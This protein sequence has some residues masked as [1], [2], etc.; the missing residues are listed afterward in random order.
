MTPLWLD[1][2]GATR[3]AG[4]L[5]AVLRAAGLKGLDPEDY[6]A[7]E[8]TALLPAGTPDERAELELRLSLGLIEITSDLASGRLEP[9]KVDRSCSSIR[10]TSIRPKSSAPPPRRPTSPRSS[11]RSSLRSRSTGACG[12]RLP[13][14]GRWP[15]RAA[16]PPSPMARRSSPA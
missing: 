11:P 7:A 16:G 15:R 1:E 12:Q 6:G 10:T 2:N 13:T 3:R 14:I 9:N 5:A 4:A 8:I